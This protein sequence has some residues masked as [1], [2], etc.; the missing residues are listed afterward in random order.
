VSKKQWE[1]PQPGWMPLHRAVF[2]LGIADKAIGSMPMY[3][4][5][6]YLDQ[7]FMVRAL[8]SVIAR[9]EAVL[10]A[11][12]AISAP[13]ERVP[14]DV[15]HL[16]KVADWRNGVAVA[17][18]GTQYWSIHVG[19]SAS[20]AAAK[21]APKKRHSRSDIDTFIRKYIDDEKKANRSP[22]STGCE[23]AWA[24]AG[25]RGDR[26]RLRGRYKEIQ[27]TAGCKVS[28]GRKPKRSSPI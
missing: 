6:S 25:H 14:A 26:E 10:Y 22:T 17:P 13:L 28:P 27:E 24:N 9:G 3:L 11:R 19:P 2:K 18:D 12:T 15:C 21:G 8:S 4:G 1:N 16:L 23:M 20:K 5:L 7:K